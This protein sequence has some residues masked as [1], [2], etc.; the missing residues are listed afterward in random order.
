LSA[1]ISDPPGARDGIVSFDQEFTV[2]AR[3]LN[4]GGAGVQAAARLKIEY[5]PNQGFVTADVAERD[6]N[7]GS[8]V[9]WKFKAP[10]RA[11]SD[12]FIIK[13]TSVPA[14][15]NTNASA[16]L[17]D[18]KS[19]ERVRVRTDSVRSELRVVSFRIIAPVGAADNVLSTGQLFTVRAQ[20]DGK[21]AV[22]A[23]VRLTLPL[24]FKTNDNTQ[25][26]FRTL[27]E[28]RDVNWTIQ[29]PSL[30]TL[31][32]RLDSIH[33]AT[34]G[35]DAN[36]NAQALPADRKSIALRVVEQA[37]L[38][39]LGE[40][41]SPASA[42][43]GIVTRNQIFTVTARML[44]RGAA[45]LGAGSKAQLELTL[46]RDQSITPAEDYSTTSSLRQEITDFANGVA[47]W[48]IKARSKAST[49]IDNIR[50]R[51]LQPY[52]R[53]EN[54]DSTATVEDVED[55]IA[56]QTEPKTLVVQMLPPP[57]AGPV[58]LGEKSSLL[59][60]L[61]LTNQGN[62]NSSNILLRG[63]TLHARD[64]DN[65][66]LNASTVI[67]ALRLVDTHRSAQ[68]FGSLTSIPATDSLRIPFAPADTLLGGV[69]D[70]VD[71][72]VDVV[73]NNASGSAFRLTFARAA[74]V[75]AIDQESRETVEIVFLDE[76]GNNVDAA[77]VASPKRVINAAN[78]EAAFYNYPNPFSPNRDIAKNGTPGTTFDYYLSQASD[79]EFRIYTLLGELVYERSY[80]ASDP[81]GRPSG[82]FK[83]LFWDGRNGNGDVVLNGV[84]LAILKTGAGTA[85]TKVAVVK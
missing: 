35:Y 4:D 16:A 47:T 14:D 29:A 17:T 40:I 45:A 9:Q 46:P 71:V 83:Q 80:Q 54:T 58:A 7:V 57:S 84:Y 48:E 19:Q 3:V 60:R 50:V 5:D 82:T 72:V 79:V 51:L 61:K 66:P 43:D 13:Y 1:E 65:K 27:D 76:L 64:R 49:Q 39:V 6:V 41:S 75:E 22:D 81:E 70:S 23:T 28:Q 26:I 34:N 30:P 2:T 10:G 15:T 11:G 37:R 53:D 36:D 62:R 33:V 73:D 38:A 85:T 12:I 63:L 25:Q 8:S 55:L 21:R 67:K 74:D 77:Q 68:V 20:V 56:I 78:F 18:S 42:L 24:G 59:M 69:P 52:P 31:V 44:N 32:G